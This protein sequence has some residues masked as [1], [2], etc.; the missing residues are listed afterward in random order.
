[1][2]SRLFEK[3]KSSNASQPCSELQV[4][5]LQI[6]NTATLQNSTVLFLADSL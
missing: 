1:M 3:G 2:S 4:N 5:K 6:T